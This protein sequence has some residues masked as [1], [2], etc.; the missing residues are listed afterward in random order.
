MKSIFKITLKFLKKYPNISYLAN[1]SNDELL[2][3]WEGLGYYS[4]ALNMH[5]TALIVQE[6][7]DGKFPSKY[8]DLIELPGI[9]DYT[10]SAVS[11]IC[12]DEVQPVVDGNVLRFLSRLYKIDLPIDTA[13]TKTYFKNLAFVSRILK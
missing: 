3:I 2:K 9:G 6:K 12:S 11:S 7:F 10:A 5:K 8:L 1:T 4:R 13:K